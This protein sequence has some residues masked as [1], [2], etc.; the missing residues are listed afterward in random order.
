MELLADSA[1][2][3]DASRRIFSSIIWLSNAREAE[4]A[5]LE[6]EREASPR[7]FDNQILLPKTRPDSPAQPRHSAKKPLAREV[8]SGASAWLRR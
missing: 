2:L 6:R 8:A 3:D 7:A 1:A 4:L 5:R